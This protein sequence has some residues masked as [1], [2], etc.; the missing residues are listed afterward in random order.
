MGIPQGRLPDPSRLIMEVATGKPLAA[1]TLE[2]KT[3]EGEEI[4]GTYR[5]VSIAEAA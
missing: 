1:T 4:K 3:F 2:K 5:I